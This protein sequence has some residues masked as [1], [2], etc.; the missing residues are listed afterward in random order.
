MQTLKIDW[1]IPV[2]SRREEKNLDFTL[3][4]KMLLYEALREHWR[5]VPCGNAARTA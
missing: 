5:Y 2:A 1:H 3:I 4:C